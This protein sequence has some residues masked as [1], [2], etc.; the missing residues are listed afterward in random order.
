LIPEISKWGNPVGKE[1]E[2]SAVA[3][4]YAIGGLQPGKN[5]ISAEFYLAIVPVMFTILLLVDHNVLYIGG[6]DYGQGNRLDF[7]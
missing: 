6:I 1:T 3:P 2:C 7:Y 4:Q 5:Q